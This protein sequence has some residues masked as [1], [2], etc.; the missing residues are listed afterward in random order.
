MAPASCFASSA[1]RS[2]SLSAVLRPAYTS[3]SRNASLAGTA[4]RSGQLPS[5]RSTLLTDAPFLA[6]AACSSFMVEV[7]VTM[8]STA[9]TWPSPSASVRY[10]SRV[11]TPSTP[12]FC[13]TISLPSS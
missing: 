9:S 10:S 6:R 8:P 7:A 13:S 2:A 3:S 1:R 11:G 5:T 12:I 4:G